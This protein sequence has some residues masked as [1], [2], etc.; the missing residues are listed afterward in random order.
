MKKL[1]TGIA[2]TLSMTGLAL[3]CG[4]MTQVDPPGYAEEAGPSDKSTD[5]VIDSLQGCVV[6][7]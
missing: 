2:I 3:A 5:S 1:L 6:L 4:G 7:A